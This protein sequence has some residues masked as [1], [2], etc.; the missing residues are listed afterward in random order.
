MAPDHPRGIYGNGWSHGIYYHS[1]WAQGHRRGLRCF[2]YHY[3]H[4]CSRLHALHGNLSAVLVQLLRDEREK[5]NIYRLLWPLCALRSLGCCFNEYGYADRLP[6]VLGRSCSIRPSCRSRNDC[7]HMGGQGAGPSNGNI[8]LGPPLWS[9]LRTNPWRSTSRRTRLAEHT[10]VPRNIR[11]HDTPRASLRTPRNSAFED[12]RRCFPSCFYSREATNRK[13]Q[14]R[15]NYTVCCREVQICSLPPPPHLRR[16]LLHPTLPPFPSCR[17][18]SVLRLHHF[19]LPLLSQHLHPKDILIRSL[20]LFHPCRR[21]PL[22][23]QLRRIYARISLG[24]GLD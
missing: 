9:T 3:E 15:L 17:P 5:D 18:H 19:C 20:Q 7:R 6:N 23:P 8:L 4:E 16:S 1:P 12:A 21:P 14:T 2:P 13:S 11:Q 10:M 22:Y 24:W